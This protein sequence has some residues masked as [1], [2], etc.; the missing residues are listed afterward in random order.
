MHL[1]KR[2]PSLLQ[3]LFASSILAG[4]EAAQHSAAWRQRATDATQSA[5]LTIPAAMQMQIAPRATLLPCPRRLGAPGL[6][7]PARQ[8]RLVAR[9]EDK[10]EDN[11]PVAD[12]QSAVK[13]QKVAELAAGLKKMVR[14]RRRPPL[15]PL[16]TGARWAAP[17]THGGGS[18]HT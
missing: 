6:R 15:P 16:P 1:C 17:T 14:R 4:T 12:K 10:P 3:A 8:L 9:A 2:S 18:H 5:E 7:R 13:Q 11:D